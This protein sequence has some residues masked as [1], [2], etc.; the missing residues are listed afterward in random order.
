WLAREYEG[1]VNATDRVFELALENGRTW[2]LSELAYW[3]WRAGLDPL[4]P[5][6]AGPTN[7][8]A[9]AIAGDWAR[10]AE[11]W[12]ALGCPYQAALALADADDEE[13][14]RRA[15]SDLQ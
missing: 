3:R 2:L 13:T 15:V 6:P 14:V 10:A 11:L 1:I 8:Y 7:P 12:T 4:V 9:A 5:V